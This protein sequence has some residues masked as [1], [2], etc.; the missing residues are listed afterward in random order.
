MIG[1]HYQPFIKFVCPWQTNFTQLGTVRQRLSHL[2]KG[3]WAWPDM[4]MESNIDQ[5][6][7]AGKALL[8]I[9]S[10]IILVLN[11]KCV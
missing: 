8:L 10:L 11:K 3:T 2:V 9:K 7:V 4:D 5:H 6:S 1:S